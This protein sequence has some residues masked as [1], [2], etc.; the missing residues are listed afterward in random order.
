MSGAGLQS[1][2]SAVTKHIPNKRGCRKKAHWLVFKSKFNYVIHD[3]RQFFKNGKKL[4]AIYDA[5]GRLV[6][7][8][9]N[10]CSCVFCSSGGDAWQQKTRG[11][12]RG[13]RSFP[14]GVSSHTYL[15]T[16]TNNQKVQHSFLTHL[17]NVFR[18]VC[19]SSVLLNLKKRF[20]RDCIYVSLASMK[21]VSWS[22][23]CRNYF[24]AP[25]GEKNM[26]VDL[27]KE[28]YTN[29]WLQK[30]KMVQISVAWIKN[31]SH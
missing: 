15:Q 26:L 1:W 17:T 4:S 27:S 6:P 8:V 10:F 31:F 14:A 19:E 2:K 30:S 11:G 3:D 25:S 9:L 22:V 28:E 20:H 24:D 13:G 5:D 23:Y 21:Q 18:E 29:L 7:K 12:R 16:H